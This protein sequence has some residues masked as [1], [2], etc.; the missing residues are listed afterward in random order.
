MKTTGIRNSLFLGLI[1]QARSRELSIAG[2]FICG[3]SE[4]IDRY[5]VTID[6]IA[7]SGL[8]EKAAIPAVLRPR[9]F[10]TAGRTRELQPHGKKVLNVYFSTLLCFTS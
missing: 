7:R 4:R 8:D 6:Q 9:C 5:V 10:S 1:K 3:S 2:T